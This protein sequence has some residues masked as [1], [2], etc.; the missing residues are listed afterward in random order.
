MIDIG[1]GRHA[2]EVAGSSRAHGEGRWRVKKVRGVHRQR[3]KEEDKRGLDTG[4]TGRE[5]SPPACMRGKEKGW[6]DA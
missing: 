1:I 5:E 3:E 2:E 6:D 4:V